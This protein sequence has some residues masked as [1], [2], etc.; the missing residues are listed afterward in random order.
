M[1]TFFDLLVLCFGLLLVMGTIYDVIAYRYYKYDITITGRFRKWCADYPL[2]NWV[3]GFLIG[4][5]VGHL[6]C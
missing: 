4:L 5:L 2:V 6:F 3:F 1:N